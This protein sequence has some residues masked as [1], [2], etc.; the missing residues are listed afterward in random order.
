MSGGPEAR[1]PGGPERRRAHRIE[2]GVPFAVLP[3]VRRSG[4]PGFRYL[5]YRFAEAS[6]NV[7]NCGALARICLAASALIEPPR[8]M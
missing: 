3:G 1:T 5:Q 8:G 2:F 6:K 7:W 4:R